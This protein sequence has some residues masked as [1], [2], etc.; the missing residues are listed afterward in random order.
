A[1]EAGAEEVLSSEEE[2]EILCQ[3]EDLHAVAGT[4]ADKF[5]DAKGCKLAWKPQ[6]L[7]PVDEDKA[8]S[9]LKFLDVLDDL[10]DVQN[11]TANYDISDEVMEKLAAD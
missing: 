10:D 3:P 4:L 1:L 6:T 8:E 11:V 9:L 2:H 5:G 7:V